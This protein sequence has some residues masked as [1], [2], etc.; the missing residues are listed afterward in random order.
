MNSPQQRLRIT[1]EKGDAIRFSSHLDLLRL[2]VRSLRRARAP[3]AYTQGF[4]P[5]PRLQLAAA[6]P[7]G[8][9][10]SQEVL[11]VLLDRA[12]DPDELGRRLAPA[13]PVGVSVSEIREAALDE[14]AL[15][16][17]VAS[18]DYRVDVEWDGT[19]AQAEQLV[20]DLLNASELP[21]QRKGKPFNLRP[22]IERLWVEDVGPGRVILNMQLAA[23]PGRTARPEAVLDA[24]GMGEPVASYHR[25]R[26]ILAT[27]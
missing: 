3:L 4:N 5:R 27:D 12:I 14:A 17:R 10:G 18:S 23:E 16:T 9:T 22:L 1:F 25:E 26:V 20:A 19:E 2:W 21:A 7:L 6:L 13:L 8:H 24:L 15:Q 11:D